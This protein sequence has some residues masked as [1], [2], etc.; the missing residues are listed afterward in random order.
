[1]AKHTV[2]PHHPG[3]GVHS[4]SGGMTMDK[5]LKYMQDNIARTRMAR[6]L[7]P[8]EKR[9]MYKLNADY[10]IAEDPNTARVLVREGHGM[11]TK[12]EAKQLA[13]L[14]HTLIEI[15]MMCD[16]LSLAED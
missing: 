12:G 6:Q 11:L 16:S 1:M 9:M 2:P 7:D 15:N 13:D 4:S 14:R 10:R 5:Q 8:Q 3:D